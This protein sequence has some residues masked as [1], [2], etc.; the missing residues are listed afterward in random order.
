MVD[1]EIVFAILPGKGGDVAEILLNRPKALNALTQVMCQSIQEKLQL[2]DKD[3][4]IKAVII[5]GA[6]DR[7]F[8]AGGDVRSLYN[9]RDN[10][11]QVMNF[12]QQEYAMNAALFHF[13]KPY[14]ALLDG[15]TMGGGAGVSLYGSHRVASE[16]FSFA[17]PE[18]AIGFFPD[19]GAGY[20][21]NQCPGKMGYYLGLSG[22]AINASDALA[23]GLVNYTVLKDQLPNLV[24]TLCATPLGDAPKNRV[25]E[26][27]ERYHFQ[28]PKSLLMPH[29]S[30][31]DRCFSRE[32]V[33]EIFLLLEADN[34]L[35]SQQLISIL[36]KRSPTS[37][38]VTLEYLRRTHLMTFDQV[39]QLNF[40]LAHA[41]MQH[42]DFFEGVRAVLVDKDQSAVWRPDKISAVGNVADY[43]AASCHKQGE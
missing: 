16:H 18:T 17:M 10:L 34:T 38:V 28:P 30:L 2:W 5:R 9:H 13:S 39:M 22:V 31:I 27:I 26:I 21:L 15:I 20:F 40:V 6:G 7:A 24:D 29:Q 14:I 11:S 12:F 19:I 33:A 42:P 3:P 1:H 32:T 43:F 41:F 23:L 35:W 37:L 8:C 36:Q 4:A 25:S